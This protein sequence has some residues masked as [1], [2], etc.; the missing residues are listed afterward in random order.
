MEMEHD[1]YR[2]LERLLETQGRDDGEPARDP[3]TRLDLL[4][5][6]ALLVASCAVSALGLREIA[7][8]Y[9]QDSIAWAEAPAVEFIAGAKP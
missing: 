4:L 8:E 6:A 2:R 5:L 3:M 9:D 7:G 1:E